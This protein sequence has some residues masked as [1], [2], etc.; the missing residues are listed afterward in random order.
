MRVALKCAGVVMVMLLTAAAPSR[1]ASFDASFLNSNLT[2]AGATFDHY[3]YDLDSL[4]IDGV[5]YHSDFEGTEFSASGGV[6]VQTTPILDANGG[7]IGT[8][9]VCLD[10]LNNKTC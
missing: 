6:L 8:S 10:V 4:W 5:D 7:I 2:F 3:G 1:A 9:S